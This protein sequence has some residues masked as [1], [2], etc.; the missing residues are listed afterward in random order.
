[1]QDL[2]VS[3]RTVRDCCLRTV[4][5]RAHVETFSGT[6]INIYEDSDGNIIVDTS[7]A[8]YCV[9]TCNDCCGFSEF[10]LPTTVNDLLQIC[11]YKKISSFNRIDIDDIDDYNSDLVFGN[12]NPDRD[13]QE[14]YIFEITFDNGQIFAFGLRSFHNGYYPADIT[15]TKRQNFNQLI[16]K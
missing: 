11:R 10:Y 12:N 3:S 9:S 4:G 8:S 15:I 13:E 14:N 7:D 2:R 5:D 1:M 6:L 16:A